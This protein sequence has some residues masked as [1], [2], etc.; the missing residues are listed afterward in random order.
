MN[1][2]LAIIFLIIALIA[3]AIVHGYMTRP[4]KVEC[5]ITVKGFPY[6][7][8][9]KHDSSGNYYENEKFIVRVK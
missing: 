4:V 7:W 1:L 2:N 9:L 3:G 8:C 5:G 6:K